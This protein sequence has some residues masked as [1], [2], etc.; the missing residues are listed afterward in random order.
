MKPCLHLGVPRS[1]LATAASLCLLYLAALLAFGPSLQAQTTTPAS[2]PQSSPRDTQQVTPMPLAPAAAAP[3]AP[4]APETAQRSIAGTDAPPTI[5]TPPTV[6]T[7]AVP[8]GSEIDGIVAIVNGDLIL[9]SDIDQERRFAALLPYGEASGLFTRD[10]ALERLIDRD[11]ILQQV[12]LQPQDPIT[13]EDAAKDLDSLRKAIPTCKE[14][15]CDT[16]AGWDKF[17]ASQGF[18]EAT[19]TG[20]WRQ[21]MVV[22]RF[23]EQRFRMGI[24]ITPEQIQEYYNKTL[25]P[26]YAAKH[27]SAPPVAAISSRIQEIL[28]QQQ[29]SNLLTDWLQSLRAQG[30]VVI[31]HPG[32]EAP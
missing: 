30:S 28:L 31:M 24:K 29:V 5:I 17:L 14:F 20:L 32:E 4:G 22:L 23:I 26:Q 12:K 1:A 13:D 25:L 15:H 11:L 16:Q 19:L 27:S 9:D 10:A 8:A 3:P 21:R 2:V 18:T 7:I 6:P